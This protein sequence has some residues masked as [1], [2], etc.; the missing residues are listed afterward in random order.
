MNDL[1]L[2]EVKNYLDITWIDDRTH[3]KLTLMIEDGIRDLNKKSGNVN[4]FTIPGRARTL[5]L[6]RVLYDWNKALDDFYINYKSEIIAFINEAKV[7]KYVDKKISAG[8]I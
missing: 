6:N 2:K 5:L 1:L 4:N 8:E 3:K 7:K